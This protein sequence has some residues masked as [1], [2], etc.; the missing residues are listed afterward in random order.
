MKEEW[1]VVASRGKPHAILIIDS[2]SLGMKKDYACNTFGF[3]YKIK[4]YRQFDNK[5]SIGIEDYNNI[6]ALLGKLIKKDPELFYRFGIKVE[7]ISNEI[8]R[9]TDK[10]KD[11][12]WEK[13]E[14]A[15]LSENLDFMTDF[16]SK[17]WSG[18]FIYSYYF[19]FNDIFI[20]RFITEL[21]GKIAN[22]DNELLSYIATPENL[23]FIGREKLDL[24]SL[25]KDSFKEKKINENKLREHLEKYSFLK[26][27]YFWGEGFTL[28]EIRTRV[29]E[30]I[31][32]GEDYIESEMNNLKPLDINLEKYELN[33]YENTIIKSTRKISYSMNLADEATNYYVHNLMGMLKEI[34]KRL[35]VE[36][37][38]LVSMRLEEIKESLNKKKSILTK[39]ELNLRLQDH[40]LIYSEGSSKVL[41]GE[42]LEAY[43]KE[44][45]QDEVETSTNILKGTSTVKRE[46][47]IKGKVRVIMSIDELDKFQKD[48]ILVTPMT[49]PTYVQIMEKSKAII[50]DEGGLLSHAA[51]I[52]RELGKPCII[53]TKIATKILHDGDLVEVNTNQ[54]VVKI[55]NRK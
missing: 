22:F 41:T 50:T 52:A 14:N 51:I 16:Q 53:G 48:E 9:W 33:D 54:G 44:E 24:L 39:E 47:K 20:E 40:A 46:E 5:R 4:N 19:Y 27:Y 32:N 37:E 31:K 6:I 13:L 21:K 55:L 7:E 2:V 35:G 28:E 17:V 36:Y 1:F 34:A 49:N 15:K 12:D 11:I 30:I 18:G 45:L 42:K 43:R 8:V 26:R 29:D 3:D 10:L 25:A 38:Q 23:T